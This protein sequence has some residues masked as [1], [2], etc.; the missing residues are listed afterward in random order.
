MFR[1]PFLLAWWSSLPTRDNFVLKWDAFNRDWLLL[2]S[3]DLKSG[4]L[5]VQTICRCM[6]NCTVAFVFLRHFECFVSVCLIC[7]KLKRLLW[8]VIFLEG[9]VTTPLAQPNSID[10]QY[11][12]YNYFKFPLMEKIY[13]HTHVT[14]DMCLMRPPMSSPYCVIAGI[15]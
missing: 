6:G 3:T 15:K 11:Q 1:F 4:V 7:F 5:A 2:I 9:G 13:M 14:V 12:L 8:S 10:D